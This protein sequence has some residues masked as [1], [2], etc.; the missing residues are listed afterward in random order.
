MTPEASFEIP[1][2]GQG[3]G[4]LNPQRC[5]GS[6]TTWGSRAQFLCTARALNQLGKQSKIQMEAPRETAFHRIRVEE[7]LFY[8]DFVEIP[9]E[10]K[11][12]FSRSSARQLE[13][14]P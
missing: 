7:N 6:R 13:L 1:H 9:K 14:L 5:L 10:I 4:G 2:F 11:W 8:F 12:W 3:V